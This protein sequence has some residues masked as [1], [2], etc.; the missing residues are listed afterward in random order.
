MNPQPV[1][2]L[3]DIYNKDSVNL[4]SCELI[5]NNFSNGSGFAYSVL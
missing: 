5:C 4:I 1:V 2:F 3:G